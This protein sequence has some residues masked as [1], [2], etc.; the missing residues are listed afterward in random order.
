M[1]CPQPSRLQAPIARNLRC[2]TNSVPIPPIAITSAP[3]QHLFLQSMPA[4][5]ANV[6]MLQCRLP[7]PVIGG[8]TFPALATGSTLGT[9]YTQLV[10]GQISTFTTASVAFGLL[11]TAISPAPY[12]RDFSKVAWH[13]LGSMAH[14]RMHV[15]VGNIQI[16]P[17]KMCWWAAP[18]HFPTLPCCVPMW[19]FY[20]SG[21]SS[22]SL[23]LHTQT[24]APVRVHAMRHDARCGTTPVPARMRL[25][26][27]HAH[28]CILHPSRAFPSLADRDFQIRLSGS[29]SI[30]GL[31]PQCPALP[32]PPT[33]KPRRHT[34]THTCT[35]V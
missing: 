35:D 19:F 30:A 3:L 29:G 5:A 1:P 18:T 28:A 20:R 11:T 10:D 15:L 2:S 12:V 14:A 21:T 26:G 34:C 31:R 23:M 27:C 32:P 25:A 33:L 9:S 13:G 24:L 16:H 4:F 7:V 8:T 17:L 6:A 22:C